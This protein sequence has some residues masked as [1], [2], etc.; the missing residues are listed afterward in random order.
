MFGGEGGQDMEYTAGVEILSLDVPYQKEIQSKTDQKEKNTQELVDINA[1][2]RS[3]WLWNSV[4]STFKCTTW[5]YFRPKA[6][7]I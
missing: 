4:K 2:F 5:E 3:R 1:S 7:L 6:V